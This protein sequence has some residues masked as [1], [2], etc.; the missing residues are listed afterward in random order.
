MREDLSQNILGVF[1]RRLLIQGEKL[2]A[3]TTWHSAAMLNTLRFGI[4]E[5]TNTNTK[6]ES[7]DTDTNTNT[8]CFGIIEVGH[9]HNCTQADV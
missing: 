7:A 9:E 8:L 5:V 6:P 3:G 1:T 2:T 4:I